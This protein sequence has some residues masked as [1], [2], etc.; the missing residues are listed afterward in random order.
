MYRLKTLTGASLWARHVAAQATE[1]SIRVFI[2]N[3]M[4]ELARPKTV[5]TA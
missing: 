1:V 5:R 3:R 2:L 4:N